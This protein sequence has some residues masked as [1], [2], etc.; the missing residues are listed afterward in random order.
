MKRG[1]GT[2]KGRNWVDLPRDVMIH[3]FSKLDTVEILSRAQFVC[4][5]WQQ[6]SQERQLFRTIYLPDEEPEIS[7]K[8]V[9]KIL[10]EAV[11]R[12]CGELVEIFI[13]EPW[14]RNMFLNY[15]VR[16]S[17]SLRVLRLA[18]LAAISEDALMKAFK[19][20][21]LLEE[22]EMSN[23]V[24][25][26]CLLEELGR[27]CPQFKHLR[28]YKSSLGYKPSCKVLELNIAKYLPQ[29]QGLSFTQM[30]ISNTGLRAIL[31]RCSLLEDLDFRQCCTSGLKE[32]LQKKCLDKFRNFQPPR[33]VRLR[34]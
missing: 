31:K 24:C 8:G 29:L 13:G 28:L 26:S 20:L 7:R 4:T 2:T 12:S 18:M 19:K 25:D 3:I 30:W 23:S 22:F 6:V 5:T 34:R 33:R 11:D 21:P 17:K 15:V 32:D 27:S 9:A 16:K 1:K 14:C 10:H